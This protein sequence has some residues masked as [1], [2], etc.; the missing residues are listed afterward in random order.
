MRRLLIAIV[1]GVV[2]V[3]GGSVWAHGSH[4][5]SRTTTTYVFVYGNRY[6]AYIPPLKGP[7]LTLPGVRFEVTDAAPRSI[8]G[9]MRPG[10]VIAQ[11]SLRVAEARVLV[12]AATGAPGDMLPGVVLSRVPAADGKH[13]LWCDLAHGKHAGFGQIRRYDCLSDEAGRG[14]FDHRWTAMSDNGLLGLAS[15]VAYAPTELPRSAAFRGTEPTERPLA[16][17]GYQ[18]CD[19]DGL[20]SPPRF[21]LA[22]ALA[23]DVDWT[24]GEKSAGCAYG[25]W[26]N[27]AD[28]AHVDVDG[29][30]LTIQ[31]ASRSEGVQFTYAGR[32][33]STAPTAALVAGRSLPSAG[34]SA[35]VQPAPAPAPAEPL[36]A[37]GAPVA[38]G[39]ALQKDQEFFSIGVR[40]GL[41]GVLM[42]DVRGRGWL[43]DR[44]LLVDQPVYGVSMAGSSGQTIIWCAPRLENPADHAA[45][46]HYLGVC[47]PEGWWV[48]TDNA[49]MTVNLSWPAGGGQLVSTPSVDRRPVD[50]PPMTLSYAFGGWT[51]AGWLIVTVRLDW[52][53]GPKLLR[54]IV[55]PPDAAGLS[56]LHV[57]GG[58]IAIKRGGPNSPE[59]DRAVVEVRSPP[60]AG[61]RVVY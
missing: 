4:G 38:T 58:E 32:I 18:W 27:P 7:V 41:T 24:N 31:V 23:G 61:D 11:H 2:L 36:I 48:K 42:N 56:T 25:V 14:R 28:H 59:A 12:E 30:I 22:V 49:M 16:T 44:P 34:A 15:S 6:S 60:R 26:P 53:E 45:V 5:G 17:L 21:A 43:A 39:G 20:A 54:S 13:V 37:N 33:S 51:K 52:G 8:E 46:K 35:I 19:G 3:G 57:M 9:V 29:R 40:H 10:D 1:T 50:L 47:M 55:I